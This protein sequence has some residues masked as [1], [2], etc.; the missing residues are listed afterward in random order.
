[1]VERISRQLQRVW[2]DRIWENS[3]AKG[4][5]G[6]RQVAER[7]RELQ[8]HNRQADSFQQSLQ[9]KPLGREE[10]FSE[11]F[12]FN[13]VE[14]VSVPI[15]CGTNWKSWRE[16]PSGWR[17]PVVPRKKFLYYYPTRWKLHRVRVSNRLELLCSFEI[18]AL[19]FKTEVRQRSWWWKLQ[20]T[21]KWKTSQKRGK[22]GWRKDGRGEAGGSSCSR[23]SCK[24]H[25][26]LNF[27]QCWSVRQQTAILQL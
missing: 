10:I 6:G 20:H 4:A 1:M 24:Q 16:R 8:A 25:F 27:F 5:A 12:L 3:W 21:W 22:R 19:G 13:H 18:D 2:E 7:G 15:F 23:Y 17:S 11:T 26:A 14:Q 9:N